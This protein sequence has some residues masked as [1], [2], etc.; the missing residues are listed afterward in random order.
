MD[1]EFNEQQQMFRDTFRKLLTDQYDLAR[2]ATP[3]QTERFDP[4]L[5]RQL[6]ELGLFGM[7]VPEEFGGMGLCW[8]DVALVVEELGRSLIHSPVCDTI[9]AAS[10]ISRHGTAKQQSSLLTRV[11]AGKMRFAAAIAEPEC[12]YGAANISSSVARSSDGLRLR[13]NK[14]LVPACDATGRILVSALIGETST[15]GFVIVDPDAGG[16]SIQ[17]HTTLDPTCQLVRVDFDDVVV[18][19]TDI[20]GAADGAGCIVEHALD[21]LNAAA[22]L[23]LVGVSERM[24]ELAVAYA[25]Q[26]VQF[27]RPIGSFQA[28]KHRCADMAVAVDSAKSAAYY[29]A[30]AVS[31]NASDRAKAVSMAKSYC[32]DAARMVCNESI[33]IHGGMGFTWELGLHY[34]LRRTKL[35]EFSYGDA[36]YHRERVLAATLD[37]LGITA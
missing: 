4:E 12:E 24:L 5:W 37:G 25:N 33:Q 28:I 21:M 9:V 7:L 6:S 16:V 34:F 11:A 19:A 35:L 36:A 14:V 22:A 10:L 3:I 2:H 1:F 15:P 8:V 17:S 23:E 27:G 31:E 30:W 26:R 18:D 29:A 32:G 13:G 20:L